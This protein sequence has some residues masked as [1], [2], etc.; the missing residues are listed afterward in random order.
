MENK[1]RK[2]R[3]I[4]AVF[5]Q[6]NIRVYQAYNPIIAQ[7]AVK[8]Q[9]FGSH[10]SRTRMT[11]IKPSFLWMMY[12]CGWAEK[13]GQE[14]VLAID[15]KR[16][17]F[18]KIVKESVLSTYQEKSGISMEEWKGRIKKSDIRCQWDPERD[19]YGNPLSYR[20]I[21]LG[22]RGKAVEQYVEEWI[23]RIE[24]IT[25]Y[26]RELNQKK[27]QGIDILGLLPREIPYPDLRMGGEK[28][29]V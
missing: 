7:E 29:A 28:Y 15:M 18:D 5:D 17:A 21:Q 3:E 27:S 14:C 9:T 2:Q 6:D 8:L 23:V 20:S 10:F 12:R 11:W 16:E 24:D 22:I 4:R 26:V 19:I 25:D 13:E 1:H